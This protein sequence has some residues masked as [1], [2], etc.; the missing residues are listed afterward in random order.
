MKKFLLGMTGL[1]AMAGSAM[2]ADLPAQTY[3]APP[4]I[5]A[6][7]YDWTGF[8]IGGNGG[9]GS[10][11]HCWGGGSARGGGVPPG[12]RPASRGGLRGPNR[13]RLPSR[14]VFWGV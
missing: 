3:K 2:A 13:Y 9:G 6:P 7:M 11:P 8:Y 10:G 5:L 4:P 12:R 1:V 14:Q